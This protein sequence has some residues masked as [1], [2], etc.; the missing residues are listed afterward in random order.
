MIVL[1]SCYRE[2]NGITLWKY[3]HSPGWNTFPWRFCVWNL[4]K[5]DFI[6]EALT[7]RMRKGTK[8][9]PCVVIPA[10]LVPAKLVPAKLVPAKAGSRE[11]GVG[12][13]GAFAIN[14]IPDCAG[15][16]S[17]IPWIPGLGQEWQDEGY[18]LNQ[19]KDNSANRRK[20]SNQT[21]DS[22]SGPGMTRRRSAL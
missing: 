9:S 1:N 15:T 6:P 7:W 21:L 22:W 4:Q 11:H 17:W 12:I 16:T 10:K 8:A 20:G 14:S 2:N 13:Q 19:C 18:S 3:F 5:I